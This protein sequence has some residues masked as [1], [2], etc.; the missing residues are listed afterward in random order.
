MPAIAA[1][2]KTIQKTNF[3][4]RQSL[5]ELD[6]S[7]VGRGFTALRAVLHA[8]RDHL[9]TAEI[10]Q[11]GAQMPTFIR[12]V[13]YEGWN[14]AKT[15]SR[16]HGKTAFLRQIEA[17]FGPRAEVDAEHVARSIIRVLLKQISAGEMDQ[18]RSA[19]PQEVRHYW[20]TVDPFVRNVS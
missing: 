10:V 12:G 19:L 9:P 3:W 2:D 17:C 8:L 1:L 11:L 14:P 13:Y 20:P 7:D 15:P 6:W 5:T 4:L 16:D 18:V